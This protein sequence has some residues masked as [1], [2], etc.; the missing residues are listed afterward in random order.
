MVNNKSKEKVGQQV[1]GI[2]FTVILIILATGA[3]MFFYGIVNPDARINGQ[4]YAD[5]GIAIVILAGIITVLT[6]VF[7]LLKDN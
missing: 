6:Y 2:I 4:N 7:G 5:T 3:I 1:S